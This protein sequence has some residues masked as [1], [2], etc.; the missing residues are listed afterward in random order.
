MRN[1]LVALEERLGAQLYRKGRG[2][3][4]S[5]PLTEQGRRF[6]PHALAFLDRARV[7][8][9]AG[10]FQ[11][12]KELRL[13]NW[14]RFPVDPSTIDAVAITH[15]HVDHCGYLPGLVKHGFRGSVFATSG[16]HALARIVLPD[17]GE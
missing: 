6:L 13:R 1:R 15:A 14:A 16:T 12:L 17:S 4:R 5:T 10:L 8:V 3:R 7:L 11:G 2:P 9:D